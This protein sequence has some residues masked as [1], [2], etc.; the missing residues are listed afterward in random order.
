MN[1]TATT[2]ITY[3]D[4]SLGLSFPLI[5]DLFLSTITVPMKRAN[6]YLT[7]LLFCLLIVL[8]TLIIRIV[9]FAPIS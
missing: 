1:S 5:A 2:Y 8:V 3:R 7:V 6:V 9:L 4:F